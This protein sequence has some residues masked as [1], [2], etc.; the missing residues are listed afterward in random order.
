[1]KL[2][3]TRV[4]VFSAGVQNKPGAT[5]KK[6]QKLRDAKVN[7]KFVLAR[8][9]DK[10]P[11]RGV[12]FVAP[13]KGA[14]VRAAKKAGFKKSPRLVGLRV[15]GN[16]RVGMSA[17]MAGAVAEAGVNLRGMAAISL[18]GKFAS[19]FAFDSVKDA[20]AATRALKAL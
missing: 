2:K 8:R 13:I 18:G 17:K 3:I 6:L 10:R 5:A 20:N 9:T 14:A 11:V 4:D 19:V 15:E 16:D 7:L 12:V 1:M